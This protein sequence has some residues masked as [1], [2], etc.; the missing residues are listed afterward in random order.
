MKQFDNGVPAH[1]IPGATW[2]KSLASSATGNCVELASLPGGQVAVRNSRFPQGPA[3]VYEA[4][5]IAAFVSG[6]KSGEFDC[7]TVKSA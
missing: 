2:V 3:L 4:A 5:E 7:L 6:A 1:E